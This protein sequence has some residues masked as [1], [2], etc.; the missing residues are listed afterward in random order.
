MKSESH[1]FHFSLIAGVVAARLSLYFPILILLLSSTA[2]AY[3]LIKKK[4]IPLIVFILSAIFTITV[5]GNSTGNMKFMKDGKYSFVA[6]VSDLPKKIEDGYITPVMIKGVSSNLSPVL[7]TPLLL[8]PGMEV[9]G[10]G[11]VRIRETRKNPGNVRI[12]NTISIKPAG[13]VKVRTTRSF[14]SLIQSL[15]WKLL[16]IIQS[17]FSK[18]T[19]SVITALT[20]GYRSHDGKRVYDYYRRTGL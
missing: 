19:A 7:I 17:G 1:A 2:I 6:L 3:L 15:R 20:I 4:K 8:K 13:A 12:K 14:T 16:G 18:E 5:H 10:V 9:T 11:S